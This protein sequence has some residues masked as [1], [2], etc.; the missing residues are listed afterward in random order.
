MGQLKHDPETVR[1]AIIRA[2]IRPDHD[3][4][5]AIDALACDVL[6]SEPSIGND[7]GIVAAS[8]TIP[9]PLR[10]QTASGDVSDAPV[11]QRRSI[12]KSQQSATHPQ[13]RSRVSTPS[14]EVKEAISSSIVIDFSMQILRV[15]NF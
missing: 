5:G 12:S 13:H 11:V 9:W 1:Q 6:A 3:G 8:T 2:G 10:R 14:G 15:D 4:A 7:P